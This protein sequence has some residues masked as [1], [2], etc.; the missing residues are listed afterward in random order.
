MSKFLI[1]ISAVALVTHIYLYWRI[2]KTW[3]SGTKGRVFTVLLL[4]ISAAAIVSGHFVLRKLP[5][6]TYGTVTM[7]IYIWIGF[8]AIL[9]P[10]FVAL[11]IPRLLYC[12]LGKVISVSTGQPLK[13]HPSLSKFCFTLAF[14]AALGLSGYALYGGL[15]TPEIAQV[16]VSSSYLPKAFDGYRIVQLSD[17]HLGGYHQGDFIDALVESTNAQKPDLV[18]ITGDLFDAAPEE[19]I[20]FAQGLK[21]LKAKQ[22]VY[23]VNGNHEFIRGD[24][25]VWTS[26][27]KDLGIK[28][29]ENE[30]V[31]L[32]KGGSSIDLMGVDDYHSDR[33]KNGHSCDLEK[34]QK[35]RSSKNFSILLSHQPQIVD[36]AAQANIDLVLSGH[37]HG[38]QFW[39]W[40]HIVSRVMPYLKGLH[41]H[42]FRTQ[43]YVSEGAGG[44]GPPFRLGSRSEIGVITLKASK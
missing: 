38:G 1:F 42:S 43:I 24:P 3:V 34:A 21:N 20:P 26:T 23:F 2:S 19:V 41:Q 33:F 15:K 5:S 4:L 35:G 9:L 28:N 44:W 12:I 30:R 18:V 32:K 27:L 14:L 22:G 36:Q 16:T 13:D 40:G 39:P 31:T 25:G 29:L 8:L 37:T 10:L 17:I 7:G 11:E 6:S